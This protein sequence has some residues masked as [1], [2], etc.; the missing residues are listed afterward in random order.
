M[1]HAKLML[2]DDEEGVIGSQNLD[3]LSFGFN[4]EAG[5][6][7]RQKNIINDLGHLIERWKKES[8]LFQS[9]LKKISFKDKLLIA[10]FKIFYP[11]F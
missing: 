2:V 11:I 5:I 6:F 9:G 3:I 8:E 4:M 10:I 1:N 7:F